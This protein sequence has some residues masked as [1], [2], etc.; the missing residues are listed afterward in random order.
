MPLKNRSAIITSKLCILFF[1]IFSVLTTFSDTLNA[2]SIRNGN[3][4]STPV[5]D[6]GD[7]VKKV[8]QKKVDTS[9]APESNNIAILPSLGYNPSFGF[10]IGVKAS[11][12][13]NF[14]KEKSSVLSAFSLE[15]VYTTKG[16]LTAQFRHNIFTDFNKWNIQGNWQFSKYL[17]TDYS[18]GTGKK[19][20]LAYKDSGSIIRY[21]FIR[22]TEKIYRKIGHNLF[23]GAGVSFD[24]RTNI[25][26]EKLPINFTSPHY[27][28]SLRNGFNPQKYSANGLMLALQYNTREHPIRSYGGIYADLIFRFNQKWLGSS[29]N[30]FQVI[31]DLRKY[32][33]LSKKNPEHVLA[34]WHWASYK[35]SGTVPYLELPNTANDTYNRSGRAYTLSRFKGLSYACFESEY[36][37][38]ITHNKLFSGVAFVNFQTA[39]DDLGKDLYQYWESAGGIGLRILLQKRSRSTLC[40]D[41][42]FG[43][44]GANGFFFGL[45]EAF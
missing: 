21:K 14:G 28:Y 23:V 26:D 40:I 36:R 39:S 15:A 29:K 3:D 17:I 5:V 6:L 35:I 7:F 4:G 22:L 43:K 42:A 44:Y 2:Q 32:L 24:I 33:S 9:K 19:N 13:K 45:N 1:T 25:N 11:A 30:A 41:Y 37:F 10:V 27:R 20:Y 8:F 18:I 31:Y 34:F 16:I 38:P 12:I